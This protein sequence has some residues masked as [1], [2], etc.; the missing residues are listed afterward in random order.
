[1]SGAGKFGG[2][3]GGVQAEVLTEADILHAAV[4]VAR[5]SGLD[6]L[7]VKAVAE[8]LGIT[9]PA[10]YYHVPD[11]RSALESMVAG[12]ALERH[13][14]GRLQ[15]LSGENWEETLVRVLLAVADLA[16]EFPGVVGHLMLQSRGI[17]ASLD[18]SSFM[19]AQLR[20]GGL[21][22]TEAAS[23]YFALTALIC[24]WAEFSPSAVPDEKRYADLAA[25]LAEGS[26]IPS[27]ERLQ[28][29][30]R[31]LVSGL[32]STTADDR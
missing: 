2:Q 17:P 18:V 29:A 21:T 11:G 22:V 7:T 9:S 25:A 4:A 20:R 15:E 32:G 12:Y 13:F 6:R 3:R 1:M 10:L 26:R 23:G 8:Q 30:L 27:R 28:F 14:Q 16:E 5:E 24:G 19:V 31:A